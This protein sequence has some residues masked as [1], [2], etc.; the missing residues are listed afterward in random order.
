MPVLKV[1]DKLPAVK[2]HEFIEVEGNGCSIGPN[3][4]AVAEAGGGGTSGASS[5]MTP[6]AQRLA[7]AIP[8]RAERL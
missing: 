7:A 5:A 3:G 2:L 8:S 6:S 4:F 1:G